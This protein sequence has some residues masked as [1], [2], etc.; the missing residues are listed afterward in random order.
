MIMNQFQVPQFIDR[1]PKIVGPLTLKQFGY[2]AGPIVFGF[3]LAA[4]LETWLAALIAFPLIILGVALAFLK[5]EGVPLPQY[6]LHMVQFSFERHVYVLKKPEPTIE[7]YGIQKL[8][9]VEMVM[10]ARAT[11]EEI[12]MKGIDRIKSLIQIGVK[13]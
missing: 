2:I 6:L 7:V 1:E 3:I 10:R 5:I 12:P 9:H 4:F 11:H 8:E 13:R